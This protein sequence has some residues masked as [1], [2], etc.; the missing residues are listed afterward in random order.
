MMFANFITPSNPSQCWHTSHACVVHSHRLIIVPLFSNYPTHILVG[1][2]LDYEQGWNTTGNSTG[3]AYCKISY[4]A[5]TKFINIILY[6]LKQW[7][8]SNICL[9]LF[10]GLGKSLFH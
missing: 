1:F 4:R 10:R 6:C 2:V 8:V 7:P 5:V 9:I 3:S